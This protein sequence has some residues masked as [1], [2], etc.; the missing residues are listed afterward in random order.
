MGQLKNELAASDAHLDAVYCC[1]HSLI[2]GCNCRKPL[3]GMLLQAG[4]ISI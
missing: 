4:K 2:D 1:P 3:A